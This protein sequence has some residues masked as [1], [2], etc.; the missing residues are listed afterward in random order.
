MCDVGEWAAVEALPEANLIVH[1]AGAIDDQL[2]KNVTL[3]R[4]QSVLRPKVD[5]V[6]HLRCCLSLLTAHYF[7]VPPTT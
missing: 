1:C 5:G 3:E 6:R 4:C 2:M 7:Y